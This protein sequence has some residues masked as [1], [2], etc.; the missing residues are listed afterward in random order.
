MIIVMCGLWGIHPTWLWARGLARMTT[1]RCSTMSLVSSLHQCGE[2]SCHRLP[3]IFRRRISR[4]LRNP[5]TIISQ[6][7]GV[8]GRV[9][10]HIGWI[11]CQERL[12]L[13]IRLSRPEKKLYSTMFT[14]YCIGSTKM[15]RWVLRPRIRV[16]ILSMNIGSTVYENGSIPTRWLTRNS[17]NQTLYLF[18]T[19]QTMFMGLVLP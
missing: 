1:R 17:R 15:I 5:L 6:Y 16:K 18:L 8:Y 4:P 11:A 13:S 14:R 2:H 19:K 3:R 9:V 10:P 7:S 12:L